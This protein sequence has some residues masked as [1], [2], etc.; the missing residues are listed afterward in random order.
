MP[1]ET[2]AYP[3]NARVVMYSREAPDGQVFR[4]EDVADLGDEWVDCPTK[5][6]KKKARKAD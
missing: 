6:G 2:P 3:E 1:T 5:V 4:P